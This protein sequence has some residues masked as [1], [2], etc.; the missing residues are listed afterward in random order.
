MNVLT[1][2]NTLTPHQKEV[3]NNIINDITMNTQSILKSND[4]YDNLL[5]LSGP[6]GTGKTYLTTQIVEYFIENKNVL[7]DGVCVT[8]P[9]HKA[10]SVLSSILRE[11]KIQATRKTIHSFLSIK[12][13]KDFKTGEE[14]FSVDKTTKLP[15]CATLLIIDESSMIS[16]NLYEYIL[17]AI[18]DG[19]VNT[20][21]FIGDPYQLLPVD[22]SK[23]EIFTL[24]QQYKLTEIVRQAKDSYIIK[25]ATKLRERIANQDF[26]NL[27]QFFHENHESE[28][29][30]FHNKDE[31]IADFYKNKNWHKED[32]ILGSY[33]NKSVDAF[34]KTIRGQFWREKGQL[35]PPTLLPGDMLRFLDAYSVNNVNMYHNGQIITIEEATPHFHETLEIKYW[36]C[37]VVGAFSQQVFRVVDPSSKLV[38]NDKLNKIAKLAKKAQKMKNGYKAK[39]Y[40]EVFFETRDMF[41]NVQYIFSST[42][43]KLQG[44][45]YDDSYID[46]FSLA[47]HNFISD[48]YKYRLTYVAIT[49]ARKNIKIFIS[50]FDELREERKVI[51]VIKKHNQIDQMLKNI[52]K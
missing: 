9:T 52:F 19:R 50:K 48:D 1:N 3:F 18:E 42:I 15:P 7:D 36:D 23:T 2:N 31:F 10:V 24:R 38:F 16:A 20:V 45:T 22:N 37:K 43:H 35:T 32:K 40:W 49:R 33:T 44:S 27:K 11:N 14:K 5:S 34:N 4:I 39:Q 8:A 21:L 29:E 41:A 25:I 51:D 47:D 6:A 26:I 28:I 12:P 46:L 13:F 17:E 30:F